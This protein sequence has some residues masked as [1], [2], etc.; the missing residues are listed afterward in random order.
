MEAQ[1]GFLMASKCS[2]SLRMRRNRYTQRKMKLDLRPLRRSCLV[3]W[4]KDITKRDS[5]LT[6]M[7]TY[8]IIDEK[9][10]KQNE[11]DAENETP[12]LTIGAY[13]C[14][15]CGYTLF[16]AAGRE[17]KF[18]G[19]GFVCPECGAKRDEFKEVEDLDD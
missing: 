10:K 18:F 8:G 12:S 19:T 14:G 11:L 15:N 16:V 6:R 1:S 17:A 13:E 3:S 4:N 7:V 9:D 5:K 2:V